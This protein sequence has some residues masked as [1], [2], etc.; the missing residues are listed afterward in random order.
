MAWTARLGRVGGARWKLSRRAGAPD[1]DPPSG[2]RTT[3]P[4]GSPR[5]SSGSLGK[6]SISQGQRRTALAQRTDAV[7]KRT[8]GSHTNRDRQRHARRL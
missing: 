7:M 5:L 1:H 2:L 3:T 8:L 6:R 4:L